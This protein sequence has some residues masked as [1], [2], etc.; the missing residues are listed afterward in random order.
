[1]NHRRITFTL[2]LVEVLALIGIATFPALLPTFIGVWRLSNTEAGWITAVYYA[3]YMISVPILV[4][5]TDR[6]D[7][8]RVLLL[9][10]LGG[11]I[12]ALGFAL[13]ATGFWTAVLFRL[14]AGISLA[15]IYMPG[16]KL[17]GD[18]TEGA[19][20]SR[21]VSFYTASFSIG[22]SLSYLLAGEVNTRFGWRWAFAIA[23]LCALCALL[24][25]ARFLPP[26]ATR[27]ASATAGRWFDFKPVFA[28]S[29][30]L[31]YIFG[32]AA[33]MWELFSLRAWIVAFLTFSQ[34]LQPASSVSFSATRIAFL[35]GLIGLPAS[36][37]GNEM[38]R[39]FGR[40]KIIMLIMSVS[41][42]LCSVI[43]F[44]ASLP[45][46]VVI[47]L[48]L[49]HAVTV[50]GDSA[51]LTAG[52]VAAAPSGYRGA[53]LALHSTLGFGAAFL[54]PLTVGMV[55][56]LFSSQMTI[57][58]GMGYLTMAVGCALGPVFLVFF[59]RRE[60]RSAVRRPM[61]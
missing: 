9:G 6:L 25:A 10:A 60:A 31:A 57:A 1:M 24:L 14:L 34:G 48:C 32:Y 61:V 44:S 16:L 54:G 26:G 40:K 20:Q 59:G 11:T 2:C 18:H 3:G 51:A 12:S 29:N 13:F 22:L 41:A 35:I 52:A 46:A 15:G 49:V 55:L 30:A 43:G 58:W 19:L 21:Y 23:A 36:I 37:A 28:A 4:S 56:D 8:R 27:T 17:L 39:I 42:L 33:H 47:G 50:V 45:F 38:A 7:A 5:V 53:T